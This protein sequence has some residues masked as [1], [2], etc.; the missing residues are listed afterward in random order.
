MNT[1]KVR[2]NETKSEVKHQFTDRNR[3]VLMKAQSPHK[4]LSILR[5]A[6]FGLSLSLPPLVGR[7]G[8]IVC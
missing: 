7:S 1:V 8:G 3:N 5:S 4:W 2:P 6:V